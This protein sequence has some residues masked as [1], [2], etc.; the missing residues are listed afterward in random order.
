MVKKAPVKP[1]GLGHR[2][3]GKWTED[4]DREESQADAPTQRIVKENN[5]C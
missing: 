1:G 2:P 4:E 3:F 5:L